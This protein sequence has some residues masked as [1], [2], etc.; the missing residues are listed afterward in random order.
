MI[1]AALPICFNPEF[2]E[3]TNRLPS[4]CEFE[5]IIIKTMEDNHRNTNRNSPVLRVAKNEVRCSPRDTDKI[6]P[7]GKF[8]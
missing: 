3:Q 7:K 2:K 4:K 6:Q 8:L 5:I 1:T